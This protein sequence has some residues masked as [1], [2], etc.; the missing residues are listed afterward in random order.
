MVI[1]PTLIGSTLLLL[2]GLKAGSSTR[3]Y[4]PHY[5]GEFERAGNRINPLLLMYLLPGESL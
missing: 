4:H 1:R 5:A 3:P 2:I